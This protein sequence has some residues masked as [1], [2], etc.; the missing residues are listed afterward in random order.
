MKTQTRRLPIVDATSPLETRIA[1]E[2]E[3]MLAAGFKLAAAVAVGDQMLL[4]F[5]NA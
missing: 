5:Q 4:I 2:C 1:N 3:V